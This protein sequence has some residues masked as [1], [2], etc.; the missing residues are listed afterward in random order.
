MQ[1]FLSLFLV[2]YSLNGFAQVPLVPEDVSP[3]LIGEQIPNKQLKTLEDKPILVNDIVY[4]NKTVV[5][6]Y[7]GG[8]C[9]YCTEHLSALGQIEQEILDL[10]YKIVAISPDAPEGLLVASE[11]YELKY[12]LYSD[13]SGSLI[14]AMG[15]AYYAPEKY[16]KML[17]EHSKKGNDGLLPVPSIFVLDEEG[18]IAFEYINPDYTKRISSELLLAVLKNL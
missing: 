5:M 6:F 4:G 15:I 1:Y 12:E 13:A 3:L 7:R 9:G 17:A 11:D 14:K 10:G 16:H 8:W 2:L 18:K